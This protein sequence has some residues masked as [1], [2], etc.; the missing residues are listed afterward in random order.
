MA[1][2]RMQR[3]PLP[4]VRRVLALHT[5]PEDRTRWLVEQARRSSDA[6]DAGAAA[7]LGSE[8]LLSAV[9]SGWPCDARDPYVDHATF[10]DCYEWHSAADVAHAV[11]LRELQQADLNAREC[12]TIISTGG[13]LIT[14]QTRTAIA[15]ALVKYE[16]VSR[17]WTEGPMP[18]ALLRLREEHARGDESVAR[19]TWQEVRQI[20][21]QSTSRSWLVDRAGPLLLREYATHSTQNARTIERALVEYCRFFHGYSAALLVVENVPQLLQP[22]EE[23][24]GITL[25]RLRCY[26]AGARVQHPRVYASVLFS[27]GNGLRYNG[28]KGTHIC[29]NEDCDWWRM[30]CDH[31]LC[32]WRLLRCGRLGFAPLFDS[33]TLTALLCDGGHFE[34]L[35][36]LCA[37]GV[38]DCE[39][40]APHQHAGKLLYCAKDIA[41]ALAVPEVKAERVRVIPC[42]GQPPSAARRDK[43]GLYAEHVNF[44]SW[45][46]FGR[47]ISPPVGMPPLPGWTVYTHAALYRRNTPLRD[48]IKTLYLL[49]ALRPGV[50]RV[51]P[52]EMLF[53]LFH[54]MALVFCAHRL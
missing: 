35:V 51:L 33:R 34:C 15:I 13:C 45:C 49:Y 32:M 19:S 5:R 18:A 50:L 17:E 30:A 38:V 20:L 47:P 26:E 22:R 12:A 28:D 9:S 43:A 2:T 39:I 36:R 27:K 42:N 31:M 21:T 10:R 41:R 46:S 29:G 52:C 23:S 8:G 25:H 48:A 4:S 24:Y 16:I 6:G 53:H 54:C 11:I 7:A 44:V 3:G 1:T 40:F 37:E 14:P